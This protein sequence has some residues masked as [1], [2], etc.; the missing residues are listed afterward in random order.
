MTRDI[1]SGE[2]FMGGNAHNLNSSLVNVASYD[3]L[4]PGGGGLP[5]SSNLQGSH[6]RLAGLGQGGHRSW[7]FTFNWSL[8]P[9]PYLVWNGAGEIIGQS[10]SLPLTSRRRNCQWQISFNPTGRRPALLQSSESVP[11]ILRHIWSLPQLAAP[12]NRRRG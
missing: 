9:Y 2:K 7:L 3:R 10:P 11:A 12:T 1:S 8:F 6:N 4:F 5:T